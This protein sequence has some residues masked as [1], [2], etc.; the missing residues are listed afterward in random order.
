MVR[1]DALISDLDILGPCDHPHHDRTHTHDNWFH[2]FTHTGYV[3][4]DRLVQYRD[5]VI[6]QSASPEVSATRPRSL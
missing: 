1:G 4:D 5:P 3:I 6:F 2:L